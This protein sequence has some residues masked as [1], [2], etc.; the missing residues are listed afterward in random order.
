M[1]KGGL[2][3]FYDLK[4]VKD[5][6]DESHNPHFDDTNID[7]PSRICI[8]GASGSG[9]STCLMNFIAKS[10]NTFGHI[11]IVTKQQEPLYDYFEKK[12]KRKEYYHSLR[13]Q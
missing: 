6:R 1:S 12:T 7:I 11:T 5:M 10:P 4:A 13:S 9:K 2:I 8:V 3:N